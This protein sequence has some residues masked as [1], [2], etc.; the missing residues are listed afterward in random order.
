MG[1]GDFRPHSFESPQPIVMKLEIY[2]Y[3]LLHYT[4]KKPSAESYSADTVKT[5]YHFFMWHVSRTTFQA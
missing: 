4:C 1:E 2:N 3:L 5:V